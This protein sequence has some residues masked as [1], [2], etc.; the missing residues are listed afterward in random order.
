[1]S[2]VTIQMPEGL[3]QRLTEAA[4]AEGVTLDQFLASAAAE[5]LSAW[6]TVDYLRER[7]ARARREDFIAFLDQSPSVPP[8]PGDE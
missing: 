3:A 2:T 7:A 8:L 5:K 6:L 4:R 1:M